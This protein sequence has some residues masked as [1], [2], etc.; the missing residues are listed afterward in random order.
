MNK[1]LKITPKLYI[2]DLV[3]RV[4]DIDKDEKATGQVLGIELRSSSILYHVQFS[5]VGSEIKYESIELK[6]K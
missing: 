2:G 5:D 6:L 4:V 1:E 3:Y